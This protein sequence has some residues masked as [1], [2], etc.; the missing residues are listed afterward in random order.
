MYKCAACFPHL[1]TIAFLASLLDNKSHPLALLLGTA[2][3]VSA[4]E[5]CKDT[6]FKVF[7]PD[8]VVNGCLVDTTIELST[9]TPNGTNSS[10]I[11]DK[12]QLS[13][14]QTF[15]AFGNGRKIYGPASTKTVGLGRVHTVPLGKSKQFRCMDAQ[16]AFS[17]ALIGQIYLDNPIKSSRSNQGRI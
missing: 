2:A 8:G 6:G 16:N 1:N 3:L 11:D 7:W 4:L 12:F 10:F 15:G 5:K 9:Y 14:A 17:S 13:T